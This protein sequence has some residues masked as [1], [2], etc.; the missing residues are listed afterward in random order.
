[1]WSNMT[2]TDRHFDSCF[3]YV[4]L[5]R[6]TKTLLMHLFD[7]V[8]KFVGRLRSY[9]L[10]TEEKICSHC[11]PG[12]CRHKVT[13]PSPIF[14]AIGIHPTLVGLQATRS[15]EIFLFFHFI[16]IFIVIL[17]NIRLYIAY[18]YCERK[19]LHVHFLSN[20]NITSVYHPPKPKPKL[21]YRDT[22][23]PFSQVVGRTFP[24]LIEIERI[25]NINTISH[26]NKQAN[27][28]VEKIAQ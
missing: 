13:R 16:L 6:F 22:A 9:L 8:W 19:F 11:C 15:R 5:T 12:L 1:M 18:F 7:F 23:T 27:P 2:F 14:N 17:V 25:L 28:E 4:D 26:S 10:E 21:M 20:V 24:F 3:L